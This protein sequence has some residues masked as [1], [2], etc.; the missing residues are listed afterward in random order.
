METAW[1]AKV[2]GPLS[3]PPVV[4]KDRQAPSETMLG[5]TTLGGSCH[6]PILQGKSWRLRDSG[7]S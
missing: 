5:S 6:V 3:L 2:T 4:S 7:L 1:E